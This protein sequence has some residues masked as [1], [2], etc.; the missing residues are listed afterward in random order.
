MSTIFNYHFPKDWIHKV[1]ICY[2]TL[3]SDYKDRIPKDTLSYF[4]SPGLHHVPDLFRFDKESLEYFNYLLFHPNIAILDY[5]IENLKEFRELKIM[6][7]GAGVGLLSVFLARLGIKCY[8]YDNFKQIQ[9]TDFSERVKK[10]LGLDISAVSDNIDENAE[11]LLC[12]GIDIKN[13]NDVLH[14]NLKYL[15]LDGRLNGNLTTLLIDSNFE[16]VRSY[17][18]ILHVYKKKEIDNV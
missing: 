5:I 13:N 7:Y 3:I 2:N 8:N 12:S 10:G 14:E 15:L 16:L 6:D 17:H 18:N 4:I 9:L 1:S 11:V